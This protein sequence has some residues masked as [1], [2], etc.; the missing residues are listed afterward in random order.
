MRWGLIQLGW[1]PGGL[2]YCELRFCGQ[3][4]SVLGSWIPGY[5]TKH[6]FGFKD[7][8]RFLRL[9]LVIRTVCNECVITEKLSQ[10]DAVEK[11]YCI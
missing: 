7:N 5:V 8:S 4:I 1:C 2:T 10:Q 6:D 11:F 9:D 3:I